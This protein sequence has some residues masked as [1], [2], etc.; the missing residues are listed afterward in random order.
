MYIGNE[1]NTCCNCRKKYIN[2][3]NDGF[4]SFNCVT[5]DRISKNI[6]ELKLN[7]INKLGIDIINSKELGLSHKEISIK[8]NCSKSTV[9]YYCNKNVLKNKN[10]K[11]NYDK[12]LNDST[13]RFVRMFSNFKSRK[14]NKYN[15]ISNDWN[16]K[17]RMS[18]IKFKDRNCVNKDE[19]NSIYKYTYWDAIEYLG[20][21]NTKC[22]LTGTPI[23]IYTDQYC[24][25]HK[26]PVSKGG[27]NSLV[28][29][30]IT[31][32]LANYSKSSMDLN[33]YLD[34][35]KLV[36]EYNGFVVTKI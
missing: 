36:L 26:I 30:G 5:N 18:V 7:T 4:C 25:D 21:I 20:G 15:K 24:L 27:D 6:H 19:R 10:L 22:Y 9:S 31:I 32:P 1:F 3:V 8:L 16:K 13:Y 29:M 2:S 11:T 17:I 35:C 34:L 28:N 12:N 33:E 23:N 14:Y